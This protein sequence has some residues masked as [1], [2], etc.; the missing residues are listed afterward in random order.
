MAVGK[1]WPQHVELVKSLQT[2]ETQ[3]RSKIT[4]INSA[5]PSKGEINVS[6]LYADAKVN[7]VSP[8]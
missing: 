7:R 4:A 5:K 2:F 1:P 8:T 6:T 3:K